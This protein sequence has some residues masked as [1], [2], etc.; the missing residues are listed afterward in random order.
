MFLRKR[1]KMFLTTILLLCLSMNVFTVHASDLDLEQKGS[2]TVVMQKPDMGG[3]FAIYRV[4]EVQKDDADLSYKLT[5]QF[6]ESRVDL[7]VVNNPALAGALE[8]FAVEEE[9]TPDATAVPENGKVYFGDLAHG[10]Y[11]VVQTVASEGYYPA[12]TFLVSVPVKSEN[13]E[14]WIYDVDATPKTEMKP[15]ESYKPVDVTVKKVWEDNGK[16]RPSSVTAGLYEGDTLKE[17]VV[18]NS[19]NQWS[20]TWTKLDGNKQWKVKEINVPKGYVVSYQKSGMTFTMKN[21]S[22]LIQT[23]QW[24]WP[25]PVLAFTG[26]VLI[27]VGFV[28]LHSKRKTR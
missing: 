3:E 9:M 27:L 15:D 10:L 7:T 26:L 19:Q 1:M 5:E 14:K 17:K 12:N 11:L 2:V 23:G 18:L 22:S 24:N 21:T 28:L 6:A 8:V 4:A 16:K 25:V 20:H 13:G